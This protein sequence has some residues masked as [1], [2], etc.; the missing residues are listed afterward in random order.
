M[1]KNKFWIVMVVASFDSLNLTNKFGDI[2]KIQIADGEPDLFCPVFNSKDKA[3]RW[4]KGRYEV[5]ELTDST[6]QIYH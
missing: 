1:S 5:I 2:T 6:S 3:D 4:S